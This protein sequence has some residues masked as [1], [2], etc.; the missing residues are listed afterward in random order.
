MNNKLMSRNYIAISFPLN[1]SQF[2]GKTLKGNKLSFQNK[3]CVWDI[4][5]FFKIFFLLE[6]ILK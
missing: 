3:R 2:K 4:E 6:D 5:V 1:H